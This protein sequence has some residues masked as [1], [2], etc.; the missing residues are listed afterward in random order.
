MGMKRDEV[1]VLA[2]ATVGEVS[3]LRAT[4]Q[5]HAIVVVAEDYDRRIGLQL[6]AA[7]AQAYV[8]PTANLPA[9]IA[10][11]IRAVRARRRA[12]PLLH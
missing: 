2:G 5:R 7:G 12:R 9:V 8:R 10:A 1:I 3:R 6:I 4:H 11:A